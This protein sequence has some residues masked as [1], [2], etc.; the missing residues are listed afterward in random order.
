MLPTEQDHRGHAAQKAAMKRHAALPQFED[1]GGVLK[2]EREIVEQHIAGA[3]TEDDAD[4]HPENEIVHLRQRDRG[5][6]A[7]Q[8]FVLDQRA[9]VNPAQHDA[10]DIGQRI[11]PDRDRPDRNGDG[12]E[13]RKCDGENGHQAHSAFV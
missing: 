8:L 1:F 10:A 13:N 7:P 6:P 4:R 5:R 12:I 2:E 11:P 3:A 9:R